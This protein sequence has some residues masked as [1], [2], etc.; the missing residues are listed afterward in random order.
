MQI[1]KLG[2]IVGWKNTE[3]KNV[4]TIRP[5]VEIYFDAKTGVYTLANRDHFYDVVLVPI[6]NLSHITIEMV[7]LFGS[8]ATIML[9]KT[10]EIAGRQ[11]AKALHG[12]DSETKVKRIFSSISK[13][14]FGRYELIS[15]DP[16]KCIRFRLQNNMKMLT[17][18]KSELYK[19][20]YLIGFY[21]G[22]FSTAFGKQFSCEERV[23]MN[24]NDKYCE[25]ELYA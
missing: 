4:L 15:F 6:S 24:F 18:E 22:Y 25:F 17:E 21:S 11:S 7:K 12:S 13:W 5:D 10:G 9:Q 20:H 16:N 8:A 14:G 19:H 3:K 23:C 2:D 1:G